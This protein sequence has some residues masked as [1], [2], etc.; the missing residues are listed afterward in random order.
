MLMEELMVFLRSVV[1]TA[2]AGV[3]A[4]LSVVAV[5]TD[6]AP[7]LE[8]FS[9]RMTAR[10]TVLTDEGGA[11]WNPR[12][13]SLGTSSMSTALVGKDIALTDM[14]SLYQVN[15]TGVTG[16]RLR[17]PRAGRYQVRLLMAESY[18]NQPG[19]RV[20]DVLSEGVLVASDVD[21]VAAVGKAAAHD[22]VFDTQVRDGM[23]DLS[24]VKKV[25][26]PLVSA[27]EVREVADV[28]DPASDAEEPQP[29]PSDTTAPTTAPTEPSAPPEGKR[30]FESRST[31]RF[32]PV[33]DSQGRIWGP[34]VLG[35]GTWNTGKSLVGKDIGNTTEDEL[36]QVTGWDIRWFRLP[37]PDKATYTVRLL[38]A[39]NSFSNPGERVFDV[40]A[41]G[42]TVATDVDIVKASG[43]RGK[44]YDLTFSVT[45]DDGE[46]TILFP[47]KVNNPMISAVEVISTTPVALPVA[48][49]MTSK[50]INF[51]PNSFWTEDISNAPVA[52]NSATLTANLVNQ[53]S[54]EAGGIAGFNAFNYAVA[55]NVV[56]P[57]QRRVRV[58]YVNCQGKNG[59]PWGLYDGDQHFVDVP[60][61]D[62][63]I[64]TTGN[65]SQ[66][67]VYD[68]AADQVWEFWKMRHNSTT[69]QWEA[70]WG[71]RLD[72]VSTQLGHF[73]QWFGTAATGLVM[74]G[75]MVTIEDIRRGEINHAMLLNVIDANQ[76]GWSWPAQRHD[77]NVDSPDVIMEG[78][79]LRL[80]PTINLDDYELT[81]VGR[82]VAKAAQKYGFIVSD[83]SMTVTVQAEDGRV[84]EARTGTN[85]WRTLLG[86]PSYHAMRNFPWDKMQVLPKDYGKP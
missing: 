13:R 35:F 17:V 79:R 2:V 15:A 27:I 6:A 34:R 68:P 52:D 45:V 39:E 75:G 21:I 19:Q 51:A 72:R 37:V 14:D 20:F 32:T 73:P 71:G 22:V 60:V 54:R 70:C 56:P 16:Y 74:A 76:S 62:G 47:K 42:K 67:T 26:V 9:S 63:A 49:D 58:E 25:N 66:M 36:Y 44:A 23:L 55:M 59:I 40:V 7:P 18:W 46:L 80:D 50:A 81:P 53:V 41:E 77:G 3:I 61:P 85:P 86:G 48:P 4:P 30:V 8:P 64:S 43:G 28:V 12:S 29:S 38:M 10:R 82:I 69:G 1:A 65:D 78:Q 5:A 33:T 11:L 57:D 84:A 83:K 31:A 24:F